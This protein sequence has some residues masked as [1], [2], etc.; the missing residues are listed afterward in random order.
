MKNKESGFVIILLILGIALIGLIAVLYFTKG[1]NEEKSQYDQGQEALD[2]AKQI[3]QQ[4]IERSI[5]IQ[6]QL[7]I[8]NELNTN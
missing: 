1:K 6:E 7:D 2:Q 4:G 8:Q 5:Q 3:N